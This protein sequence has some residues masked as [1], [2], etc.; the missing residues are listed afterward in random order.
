MYIH[1][2]LKNILQIV[3]PRTTL[4]VFVSCVTPSFIPRQG[5]HH[6]ASPAFGVIKNCPD[7][8]CGFIFNT[9]HIFCSNATL[10]TLLT[11]EQ[12]V[13][14]RKIQLI[15]EATNEATFYQETRTRT[16]QYENQRFIF[17]VHS[18]HCK[19]SIFFKMTF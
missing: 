11:N 17:W 18:C 13:G 15:N 5:D 12:Q 9:K 14:S 2:Y 4:N 1:I 3:G 10:K 16:F 8:F 6:L 7:G 19:S